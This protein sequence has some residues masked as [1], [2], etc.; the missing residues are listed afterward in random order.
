[1]AGR[2]VGQEERG[3]EVRCD[4]KRGGTGREVGQEER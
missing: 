2:E 1:M 3:Q 4:R